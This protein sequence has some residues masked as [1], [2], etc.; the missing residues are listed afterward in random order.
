MPLNPRLARYFKYTLRILV[1]RALKHHIAFLFDCISFDAQRILHVVFHITITMQGI[2]F[3]DSP[4]I[5][6]FSLT[7]TTAE[8]A[9]LKDCIVR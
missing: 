6:Y 9:Q 3:P 8:E 4:S 2:C 7:K 1:D 5:S